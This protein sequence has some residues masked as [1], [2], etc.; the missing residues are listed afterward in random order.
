M[1][2]LSVDAAF[3]QGEASHKSITEE[4]RGLEQRQVKAILESDIAFLNDLL[5]PDYAVNAPINRVT[6]KADVLRLVKE[7][8]S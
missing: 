2:L 8:L 6:S 3:S 1:M 5:L 4:I 7:I